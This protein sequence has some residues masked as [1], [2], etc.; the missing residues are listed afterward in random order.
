MTLGWPPLSAPAPQVQPA[1]LRWLGSIVSAWSLG[2]HRAGQTLA[3]PW[4]RAGTSLFPPPPSASTHLTKS[5]WASYAG[6][7]RWGYYAAADRVRTA[8]QG[9]SSVLSNAVYPCVFSLVHSDRPQ[10]VALVR[11]AAGHP[12]QR[13]L[14]GRLRTLAS[15]TFH[16]QP[17]DGPG[18][19]AVG[20]RAALDGLRALQRQ[21]EQ[22]VW[23]PTHAPTR[24]EP[25]LQRDRHGL[26]AAETAALHPLGPLPPGPGCRH[27]PADRDG[28][29]GRHGHPYR[30]MAAQTRRRN[31]TKV[32]Q[33][34]HGRVLSCCEL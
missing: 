11:Q 8:A 27:R 34:P 5:S 7:C 29:D 31:G 24:H 14:L 10:A 21:S 3:T 26:R 20:H 4:P 32:S 22:R 13:Y 23:H 16:R 19:S 15:R 28:R 30:P 6:H 12:R 1:S 2:S 9:V 25:D 17:A 33:P 18:V